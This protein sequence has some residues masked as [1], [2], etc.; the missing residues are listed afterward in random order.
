[1]WMGMSYGD[2]GMT[3]VKV[4]IHLALIVPYTATSALL[5]R[6]VEKRINVK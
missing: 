6:Y 2:D 3:S 4:E 1:M 5:Y